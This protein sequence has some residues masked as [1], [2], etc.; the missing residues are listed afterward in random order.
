MCNRGLRRCTRYRYRNNKL[1]LSLT[2]SRDALPG[3]P[4]KVSSCEVTSLP[5]GNGESS[6][7]I[8]SGL[9]YLSL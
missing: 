2:I 3:V 6:G 5:P 8:T 1:N 7:L 9:W 4:Q